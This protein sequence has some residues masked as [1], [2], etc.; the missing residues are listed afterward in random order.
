ML[1]YLFYLGAGE[2]ENFS[3]QHQADL[4]KEKDETARLREELAEMKH[5]HS[6]ELQKIIDSSQ[7]EIADA[8]KELDELHSKTISDMQDMLHKELQAEKNLRDLEKKQNDALEETKP[9]WAKIVEKLDEQVWGNFSDILIFY[10]LLSSCWLLLMPE[11][12]FAGFS[13]NPALPRPSHR[14]HHRISERRALSP[15]RKLE[16]RGSC[17]CFVCSGILYEEAWQGSAGCCHPHVPES[18]A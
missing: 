3:S 10:Y 5:L 15:R 14:S 12:L 17:D 9:S 2:K 16:H 8:Q 11:L 13:Y 6:L 4:Q 1:A 18:L 7:T